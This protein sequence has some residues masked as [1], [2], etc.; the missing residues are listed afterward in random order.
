MLLSIG[1]DE[2]RR[3]PRASAP[4]CDLAHT[5]SSRRSQCG[6]HDAAVSTECGGTNG[7]GCSEE[8]RAHHRSGQEQTR[9]G[10]EE[11]VRQG[12]EHPRACRG[13]WA[14]VWVRAPSAVRVRNDPA[15]P[16]RG[17]PF[18][19]EEEVALSTTEPA[20]TFDIPAEAGFSAMVAGD[21]ATVVL[22]RPE[23]RN[24]QTPHTWTALARVARELPGTVRVVVLRGA[25][26]SFSAGLDRA[27]FTAE[28][29]AGAPGV[30]A[31]A[32]GPAEQ[33]TAQIA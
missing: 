27:M 23:K 26:R 22:N 21:V 2:K 30:L 18:Q 33:A 31:L 7:N 28:G 8:G 1:L 16:W 10:S 5:D 29:V 20:I 11:A 12:Q 14:L 6:G 17:D 9:D 3:A 15:W 32:A 13:T 19:G 25:G 24:V 4:T